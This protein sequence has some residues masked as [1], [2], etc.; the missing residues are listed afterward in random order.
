MRLVLCDDRTLR[1]VLAVALD[2]CGHPT[3]ARAVTADEAVVGI[4]RYQRNPRLMDYHFPDEWRAL[5]LSRAVA[6]SAIGGAAGQLVRDRTSL[7]EV[8]GALQL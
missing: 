3:P 5:A 1:E 2:A 7:P 4:A 8:Q 6:T